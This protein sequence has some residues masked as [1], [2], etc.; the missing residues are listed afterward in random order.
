MESSSFDPCIFV[1]FYSIE[2]AIPIQAEALLS[3]NSIKLASSSYK[4]HYAG[5]P[6]GAYRV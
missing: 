4:L 3:R 6:E 2:F 1:L 5:C